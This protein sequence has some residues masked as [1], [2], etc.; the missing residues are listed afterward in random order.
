MS[1]RL[2]L[3]H[4]LRRRLL[5]GVALMFVALNAL[6]AFVAH[7]QIHQQTDALLLELATLEGRLNL[8][9]PDRPHVHGGLIG[10][11][12]WGQQFTHKYALIYNSDC[13]VISATPQLQALSKVPA[14]WCERGS[15]QSFFTEADSGYDLRMGT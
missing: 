11:P 14:A 6:L 1:Q 3:A 9:E 4:A 7:H 15:G 8:A 2:T 5:A 12:T 10:V 13:E